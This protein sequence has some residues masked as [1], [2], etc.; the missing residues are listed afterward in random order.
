MKQLFTNTSPYPL[1]GGSHVPAIQR[2]GWQ[3]EPGAH[4]HLII[5]KRVAA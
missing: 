4:H 1:S 3:S 5:R 2:M